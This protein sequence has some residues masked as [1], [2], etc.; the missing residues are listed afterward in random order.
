MIGSIISYVGNNS[1]VWGTGAL[2]TEQ[3]YQLN[4]KAKYTAV[5]GPLT[6]Q[7]LRNA[8][9]SVSEVYG[10][11]ALLTPLYFPDP[12]EKKYETGLVLR[13]SER[14]WIDV[15][16]SEGILAID[17]GDSDVEKVLK[18]ILSCKKRSSH[19]LYID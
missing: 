13:W 3:L 11:P 4:Q 1:T 9:I 19:L 7:L 6:R 18:D 2:G 8:R 16:A 10:D 5:R 12:R 14:N 17:L 15:A